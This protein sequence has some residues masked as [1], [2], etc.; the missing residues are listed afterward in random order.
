[1][2]SGTATEIDDPCL[3]PRQTTD[4]FVTSYGDD[5]LSSD[6]QS[7]CNMK[8]VIDSDNFAV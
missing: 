7:R 1:M 2:H 8:V 6:R 5:A 4:Q 3:Y